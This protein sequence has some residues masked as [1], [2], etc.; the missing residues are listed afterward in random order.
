MSKLNVAIVGA[1]PAGITAGLAM[2]KAG[3]DCKVYERTDEVTPLGGAIILNAVGLTIMRRLGVNIEDMYNGVRTEFLRYDGKKRAIINVDPDLLK[4]ANASGWQSGMMR[5]EL[6]ARMLDVVPNDLIVPG[7]DFDRFEEDSDGV[8]LYF[9]N[10][11]TERADIV[12]GADG[13]NSRI[14]QQLY[15]QTPQPKKLGIAVWLGWCE[16]GDDVDTDACLVMH[17]KNY[18]MGFC[19]LVFEGKQCYEWWLVEQYK[20]EPKPE[21]VSEYVMEKVGHFADPTRSIIENTDHNHQLFRWIVEYIPR[22]KQW[23]KGRAT[24]MGDAAHPTSPYA[25]YG[26][27]MA[28]EDGY[29]LAKK[30]KDHAKTDFASINHALQEY[31]DLRRPYTNDTTLFARNLGRIYHS[32]PQP[33]RSLRDYFLDNFEVSGKKIEEGFTADAKAVLEQVLDEEF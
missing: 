27:G 6:Y 13:I 14:R 3:I 2:R 10:G 25:A 24:L 26:A 32:I 1:G 7:H 4:R 17:S 12:V 9:K 28:I 29:Y 30:L 22:M 5:K 11:K 19:P 31:D 15:P 23:S 33:L 16:A 20:G 21:N 8:T 18:Q